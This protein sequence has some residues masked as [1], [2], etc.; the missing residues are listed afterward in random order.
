MKKTKEKETTN[1]EEVTA[2]VTPVSDS[3]SFE[4]TIR[5]VNKRIDELV[6][7]IETKIERDKPQVSPSTMNVTC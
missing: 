5:N 2:A 7:T 4:E 6:K 1:L 3:R